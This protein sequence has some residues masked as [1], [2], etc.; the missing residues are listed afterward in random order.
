[1]PWWTCQLRLG[2]L[3]TQP[4]VSAD[5]TAQPVLGTAGKA[6]VQEAGAARVSL[7]CAKKGNLQ[8]RYK[9]PCKYDTY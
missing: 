4:N 1:M 7:P 6:V 5:D 3:K 8:I 2:T 9:I